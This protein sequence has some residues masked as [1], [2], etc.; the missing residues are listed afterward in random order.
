[1][2]RSDRAKYEA[3]RDPQLGD[4]G[5]RW[6]YR[7]ELA[8]AT[9]RFFPT[10]L[11]LWRGDWHGRPFELMPWQESLLSNLFGWVEKDSDPK[12]PTR[13]FRYCFVPIARGNGKSELA[14][15]IALKLFSADKEPGAEV[16]SAAADRQQAGIVFGSARQMALA[17]PEIAKRVQVY[18][19][20]LWY[21]EK[22]SVYRVLSSDAPRQHGLNP[23][24]VIFD[25][26]HTQKTPDLYE[27]LDSALGKRRQPLMF[28]IT[29]AGSDPQSLCWQL[30]DYAARV[31]SG[32]VEDDRFYSQIYAADPEDDIEDPAVWRKANPSLGVTVTEEFLRD[33][34][35]KAKEVPALMSSFLRL[36]LNIWTSAEER[37]LGLDVWDEGAGNVPDEQLEQRIAYAGLDLAST[38]DLSALVLVFPLDDGR[39]A[40]RPFFWVPTESIE[41]RSRLDRVPYDEWLRRGY[42]EGVPGS[43][44]DYE[45]IRSRLG[46]LRQKYDIREV[47]Y[48]PWNAAKLTQEL[49]DDGFT[50]VPIRQGFASLTFP[51][52]ATE[53]LILSRKLLHGGNP[54]LRWNAANAA[55]EQDA[56]GNLKLSKKK[57]RER[58]DGMVAL[59]LAVGRMAAVADSVYAERGL[60]VLGG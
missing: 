43:V 11:R 6:E 37:W 56:A 17:S 4:G 30:W 21:P 51:T 38:T 16:Y 2:K 10:L 34:L 36:H 18:R 49:T 59:T 24:G 57:S 44:M 29:T 55:V 42:I 39:V 27:A 15:G 47:A 52:K 5:G 20:H 54:V 23:H 9:C 53:S 25:E 60:M 32:Q 26:V 50:M 14:S 41:R 13:R 19:A 1:M 40:V 58:I 3:L 48:D 33:Q 12:A 46:V 45:Y 35:K 22:A 8:E 7:P 31:R 28:S